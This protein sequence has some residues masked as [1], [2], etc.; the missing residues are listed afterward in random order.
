MKRKS[1][2]KP[3]LGAI[4]AIA[5]PGGK[6]A[7]AKLFKNLD[8]GVYDLVSSKIEPVE[9]VIK[10]KISFFQHA[11]DSAI[12]SGEWP[13]IG[14]QPFPNDEAAWGPPRASGIL[15]GEEDPETVALSHKGSRRHA[16][17]KDVAGL[18]LDL[19]CQRPEL[20][21]EIIVDRLIKGQHKKYQVP[22]R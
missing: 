22:R 1:K 20:C 16:T 4:V 17:L 9:S 5:L 13:I 3:T 10:R 7:F 19:F 15:P 14:E 21:V 2:Q 8:L 18:D 11:T 6:F 12:K